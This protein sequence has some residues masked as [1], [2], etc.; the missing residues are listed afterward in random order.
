MA[1][2]R[3]AARALASS[4]GDRRR[5]EAGIADPP[6]HV[7]VG[8]LLGLDHRVQGVHAVEPVA[9]QRRRLH[10]IEHH[11]RRDAL[12]VGRQLVDR[13]PAIGRGDRLDPLGLERRQIGRASSCRRC[14]CESDTI[15][16]AIG[17]R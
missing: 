14:A 6:Q 3:R 2:A 16:S 17:P 10:E 5:R 9:R 8:E 1:A 4:A 11:Q 15:A 13:P 7:G 12:R